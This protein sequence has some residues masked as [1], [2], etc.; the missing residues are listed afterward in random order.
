VASPRKKEIRIVFI[1][2][3]RVSVNPGQHKIDRSIL[4]AIDQQRAKCAQ[5]T[6]DAIDQGRAKCTRST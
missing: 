3:A 2:L 5:S 6:L 4:D 1:E